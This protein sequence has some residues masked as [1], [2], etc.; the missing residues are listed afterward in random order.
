MWPE[1]DAPGWFTCTEDAGAVLFS[2]SIPHKHF[3]TLEAKSPASAFAL[4]VRED[5]HDISRLHVCE[6]K[7]VDV[8]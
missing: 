8:T 3:P 4:Q 2:N 6:T 1:V 5:G 7:R